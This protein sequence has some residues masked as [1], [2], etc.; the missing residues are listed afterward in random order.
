LPAS[1]QEADAAAED[2][3]VAGTSEAPAMMSDGVVAADDEA[4]SDSDETRSNEDDD[5]YDDDDDDDYE[6][7]PG[8]GGGSKIM[9]WVQRVYESGSTL[10]K[11]MLSCSLLGIPPPSLPSLPPRP[12][13]ASRW[14]TSC[15]A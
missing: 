13:S 7:E 3:T 11:Y 12:S 9:S 6:D 14:A 15:P 8:G 4:G 10:V 2:L 5:D 1:P